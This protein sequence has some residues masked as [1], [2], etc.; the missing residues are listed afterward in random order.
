MH[1]KYFLAKVP[2]FRKACD[3][4]T[5]VIMD[6]PTPL[7][8]VSANTSLKG[9]LG[10]TSQVLSQDKGVLKTTLGE[11]VL[12]SSVEE[13]CNETLISLLGIASICTA[14]EG[15]LSPVS[16]HSLIFLPPETVELEIQISELMQALEDTSSSNPSHLLQKGTTAPS[17]PAPKGTFSLFSMQAKPASSTLSHQGKSSPQ[18]LARPFAMQGQPSLLSNPVRGVIKAVPSSIV[19]HTRANPSPSQRASNE[20]SRSYQSA[21]STK[22]TQHPQQEWERSAPITKTYSAEKGK[23]EG[24]QERNSNQEHNHKDSHQEEDQTDDVRVWTP[25]KSKSSLS[26]DHV[27]ETDTNIFSVSHFAY[28]SA[29]RSSCKAN[30]ESCQSTFQKKPPS[31]MSL[32]ASPTT[33]EETP[34]TPPIENVFLRFMK[35][36]A[37]ILGQAEAEAHELYLRVKERTD[38]VDTLT[39]LLSKI[40]NEKG[41][42]DWN[43]NEEMQALVDRAKKLGVSIGDSYTWSEDEKKLLKEN[44]QMR[45]ENME[46]ITQLERTDMQRLLQEVSQCHQARSNVLKLLKE[47]MDTFIYNM[48][49]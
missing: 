43:Q 29:S 46:K 21:L 1:E 35:L 38:N 22:A 16:Q 12:S 25:K 39:L 28:N 13:C 18:P 2:P 42:I 48:R 8:S 33:T 20:S 19:P 14:Q 24:R 41:A 23:Q 3:T 9:D 15:L 4:L 10:N 40:N 49:P 44:I 30:P 26:S 36:M 5:S 32:F 31:P 27:N 7:S 37:R 34:K 47:L 45:K 17:Q 6:T 11:V